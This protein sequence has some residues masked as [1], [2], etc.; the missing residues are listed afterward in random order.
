MV[1]APSP[2]NRSFDITTPSWRALRIAVTPTPCSA[3]SCE[4]GASVA[5]PT[6][7]PSTTMFFQEGCSLKP[8]PSGPAMLK[9]SPGCN[10]A[11]PRVPRPSLL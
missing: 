6:P 7:R 8:T 10:V 5:S 3:A 9:S 11:M 4:S 2:S 1:R